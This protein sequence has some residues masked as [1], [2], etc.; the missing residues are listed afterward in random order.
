MNRRDFQELTRIRLGEA[1]C[2]LDQG[3]YSGA[4]Y[5]CGYVIE[6]ALKSC[7]AKQTKRHDFP[8]DKDT[9]RDIYTHNLKTLI[10]MAGLSAQLA[11]EEKNDQSF[12]VF[13]A[14]V[15]KWAERSRYERQ[16]MA[17]AH[18]LYEAVTHRRHGV[19][20]WIKQYW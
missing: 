20:R 5:L 7:V 11:A 1:K 10:K 19:L 12:A 13:W 3:H 14:E 18:N 17:D 6:C 2:L 15:S 8:P 9:V 4:Y 16:T